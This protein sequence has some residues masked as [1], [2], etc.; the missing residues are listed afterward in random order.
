M[1]NG[2]NV[3]NTTDKEINLWLENLKQIMPQKVMIYPIDRETPAK[4]IIKIPKN[5]L[6]EIG[7]KVKKLNIDVSIY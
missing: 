5:I 3:D 1:I 6:N 2:I 4:N 7:E